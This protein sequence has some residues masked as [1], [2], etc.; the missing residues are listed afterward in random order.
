M[1]M[2]RKNGAYIEAEGRERGGSMRAGRLK[3]RRYK[4][5]RSGRGAALVL[6]LLTIGCG[7]AWLLREDVQALLL[8]PAPTLSPA[9][10][11]AESRTVTLPGKTWYTLQLGVFEQQDAADALAE[12]YRGRGAGGYVLLEEHYRVLAAGYETRADAQAVQTQL[13]TGHQVDAYIWELARPEITMRLSGQRAQLTALTDALDA[14]DKLAE[15]LSAL[16]QGLDNRAVAGEEARRALASEQET[17]AALASRLRQ[18]F[19]ET[20]HAAVAQ[21][22]LLLDD[23]STA[24]GQTA[25]VSGETRLGAQIKYCQ[26][27]CISR[28]AAF[29]AGLAP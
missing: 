4:V 10:A 18:L 21:I 5:R 3:T 28:M 7:A 1:R 14:L 27:L 24:L 17:A 25:A 23:L 20:P 6:L 12:S 26:L 8:S 22:T 15:H 9:D 19:G 13:R 16:S 29:A 11:A 2:H